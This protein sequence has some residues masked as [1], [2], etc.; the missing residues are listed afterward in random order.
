MNHDH[1]PQHVLEQLSA[2]AAQE[3]FA[4][5]GLKLSR[6]ADG[7]EPVSPDFLL[8]SVI[9]FSGKDIRGTLVLALTEHIPGLSN[10]LSGPINKVGPSTT[11]RDW[12]GELANQ[13]LGTIKIELLRCGVEIS[14][15]LPAVLRGKHLAPLPRTE[16]A[17]LKFSLEGGTV[18]VWLEVQSRPGFEIDRSTIHDQSGPVAG[19]ALMWD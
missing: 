8:C 14:M 2:T 1:D 17:P 3:L 16:L 19:D 11:Q 12:V 10:P 4:R 9:G 15:N 7:E 18:A 5:Y 13:L 6:V